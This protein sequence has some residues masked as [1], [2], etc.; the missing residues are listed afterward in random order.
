MKFS[1]ILTKINECA[2]D[3]TFSELYGED[4][5]ILKKQKERYIHALEMFSSTFPEDPD[6][7]ISIFSAPG[8]TEICGNH[9]DHQKGCVLAA[10]V[11]LDTVAVVSSP[12][13][14]I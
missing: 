14:S 13:R 6:R 7:D 8:R 1:D 11:D 12:E 5:D 9:T 2:L 3:D 10:S 4:T